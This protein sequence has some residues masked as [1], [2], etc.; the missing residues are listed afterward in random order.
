MSTPNGD[1]WKG[2][3][4]ISHD[5]VEITTDMLFGIASTTKTYMAAIIMQLYEADSLKL[6]DSIY[7]WLPPFDN[8][9]STVTIRQLLNHTSGIY[10][11][12]NHPGYID[13]VFVTGSR[14]WTPEEILETFVL[15]PS[16]P[17]GTDYEYSNTNFKLLGMIIEEITGNEIVSELH[18]RITIPLELSSTFLFPD[19]GYEG[20]R[21]HVWYPDWE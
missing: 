17:P 12:T 19:E 8:I 9:D 15:E 5:T 4:G 10:N 13:S 18:N 21:S 2:V 7:K 20:V 14:I 1:I 11:V 16:F 3:S 6:S